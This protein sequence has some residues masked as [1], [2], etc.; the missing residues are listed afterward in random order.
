MGGGKAATH[1]PLALAALE[2]AGLHHK[3]ELHGTH[4]PHSLLTCGTHPRLHVML[5]TKEVKGYKTWHPRLH[6]SSA[7]PKILFDFLQSL[8][9]GIQRPAI[10]TSPQH[11]KNVHR[12]EVNQLNINMISTIKVQKLQIFITL[13]RRRLS[14]SLPL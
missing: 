6:R 14:L 1:T 13:Y 12:L 5:A 8:T 7:R 11:V 10:E 4:Q 2:H 3:L 9:V